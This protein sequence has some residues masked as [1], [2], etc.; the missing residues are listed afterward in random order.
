MAHVV[1]SF[2]GAAQRLQQIASS[3]RQSGETAWEALVNGEVLINEKRVPG[4]LVEVVFEADG[5]LQL[6][7]RRAPVVLALNPRLQFRDGTVGPRFTIA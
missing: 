7:Y 4:Q 3:K 2:L 5:A 6:G 1:L